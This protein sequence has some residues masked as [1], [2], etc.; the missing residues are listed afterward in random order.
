MGAQRAAA[1]I[2]RPDPGLSAVRENL[3]Q[4]Q[5]DA[6]FQLQ[7][8]SK[9]AAGAQASLQNDV[10]MIEAANGTIRERNARAAEALRRVS[11]KDL[12]ED[13]EAWL[14]WWMEKRGYKYIPPKDRDKAT[15]DM[16][17]ALPYLPT[18]GPARIANGNSVEQPRVLHGLGSRKGSAAQNWAVFCRRDTPVLTP[19]GFRPSRPQARRSRH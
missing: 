9:V 18:A 8:A 5:I 19:G 4:A 13:R 6:E 17:V 16:Q 12:G 15:V 1:E 10:N 3:L 14:K 7:E 2:P 11:G